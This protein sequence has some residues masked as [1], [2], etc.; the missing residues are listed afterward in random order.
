M[1]QAID[2]HITKLSKTIEGLK[3]FKTSKISPTTRNQILKE[4]F[5][6]GLDSENF[7]YVIKTNFL[8]RKEILKQFYQFKDKNQDT[9]KL[10]SVNDPDEFKGVL[11]VG[12][13]ASL[14]SRLN[15]HL[16]HSGQRVYSLQ[17][18]KWFKKITEVEIEIIPIDEK[19]TDILYPLENA[20]WDF[21]KP[22]FGKKG[23]NVNSSKHI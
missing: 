22:L 7:L 14:D 12:S 19:H 5:K 6:C 10:S 4:K 11:Y 1:K 9:Y 3:T 2:K 16:G 13:S 17:L 15:Q 21:H 20:L 18:N 23:T 8:D